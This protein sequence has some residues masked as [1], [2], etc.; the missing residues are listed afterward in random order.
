MGLKGNTLVI[1]SMGNWAT[2]LLSELKAALVWTLDTRTLV[3][4]FLTRQNR[5]PESRANIPSFS[6]PR[7]KVP[8]SLPAWGKSNK[9][10]A[11]LDYSSVKT[12]YLFQFSLQIVSTCPTVKRDALVQPLFSMMYARRFSYSGCPC[13]NHFIHKGCL[14]IDNR[15]W[16]SCFYPLCSR[17]LE[18]LAAVSDNKQ[19]GFPQSSQAHCSPFSFPGH[20]IPQVYQA[21]LC[22]IPTP[23]APL[24]VWY[25]GWGWWRSMKSKT[26]CEGKWLGWMEGVQLT[27]PSSFIFQVDC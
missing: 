11:T 1:K 25:Q 7:G 26:V 12:L 9:A 8:F 19:H 23:K 15:A 13:I 20:Q 22:L 27:R 21:L 17:H 16:K 6:F 24:G 4:L 18:F 10:T 14:S 5:C 3:P 2:M